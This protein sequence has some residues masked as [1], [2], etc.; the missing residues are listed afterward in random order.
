LEPNEANNVAKPSK[1]GHSTVTFIKEKAVT[2]IHITLQ[3]SYGSSLIS[4]L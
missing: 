1:D 2:L 4:Q 3:I